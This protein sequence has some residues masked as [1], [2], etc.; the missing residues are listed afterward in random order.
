MS[1]LLEEYAKNLGVKIAQP[2]VKGHFFPFVGEK[3]I[4]LSTEKE[5]CAKSYKYYNL[6]LDLVR[7][8]LEAHNIKIIS[9]YAVN[10]IWP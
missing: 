6:A 9:F 3:Y 4:T 5:H 1:H 8:A 7:P 10:N 2:I